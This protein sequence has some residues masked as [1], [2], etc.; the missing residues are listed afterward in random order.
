MKELCKVSNNILV[1]SYRYSLER[2][3][4]ACSDSIEAIK[5]NINL[6]AQWEINSL[7]KESEWFINNFP[8]KNNKDVR[9]FI[10]YLNNMSL[11]HFLQSKIGEF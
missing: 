3:T 2:D 5:K 6:F 1:Y 8:T 7:I 10:N 9:E 4:S 11:Q